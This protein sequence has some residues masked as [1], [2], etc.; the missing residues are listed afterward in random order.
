MK[1]HSTH[2]SF[3]LS[4]SLSLSFVSSYQSRSSF[5][6]S[7]KGSN[8]R[9]VTGGETSK[10]GGFVPFADFPFWPS[11]SRAFTL[12]ELAR[13]PGLPYFPGASFP[14]SSTT[15]ARPGRKLRSD[16]FHGGRK[17][18]SQGS[19]SVRH[20]E[21]KRS[22][23]SLPLRAVKYRHEFVNLSDS[24]LKRQIRKTWPLEQ[25]NPLPLFNAPERSIF[26]PTVP[27]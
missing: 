11:S 5:F 1:L 24:L 17:K 16:L 6:Y 27:G 12:S 10:K 15:P 13:V 2:P 25:L 3:S 7:I 22:S 19:G 9:S 18:S 14:S 23:R 21:V 20:M 26:K 4:L 8:R